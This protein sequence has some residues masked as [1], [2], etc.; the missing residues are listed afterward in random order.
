MYF[1][2]LIKQDVL[3]KILGLIR[4]WDLQELGIADQPMLWQ[5]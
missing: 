3:F 1:Q 4:V 5:K 2:E